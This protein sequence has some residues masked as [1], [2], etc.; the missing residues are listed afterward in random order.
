M[1]ENPTA[2]TS[3]LIRSSYSAFLSNDR[4]T[5]EG[6]LSDDFVFNSPRDDHINKSTY[7][8]RCFPNSDP[9]LSLD[10]EQLF[11]FGEEALVRYQVELKDGTRFR[12][13]EYLRIDKGQ[14]KEVDVFFGA[15][16]KSKEIQDD[17]Q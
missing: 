16:L 17:Q 7:F 1:S 8:Q 10:I 15:S 13:V 9:F 3:D 2:A 4:E 14:I 12:N 11:V 6:L 5:M